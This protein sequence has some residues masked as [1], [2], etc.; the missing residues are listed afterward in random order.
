MI[1]TWRWFGPNDPITL[2][3]VRQTGAT[4]IVTS[5]HE[6][7]VGT[8]WTAQDVAERKQM[9]E[10]AGLTWQVC[11]SIPVADAIK[12]GA[13]EAEAL[14][15]A[16][17][18][19]LRA[20]GRAGVPV[21]CYN[22]MPVVDWTRTT[23]THPR[24]D[25]ARAL[26]FEFADF[27]AYDLFMLGRDAASDYPNALVDRARDR[28]TAMDDAAR[29]TLEETV[30][31]GL[32]GGADG[33]TRDALAR[34]IAAFDGLTADDVRANLRRFLQAVVPV[35]Q[36]VG[37]DL[38]IHPDDPPLALFGLP[39]VVSSAA[40]VEAILD[41]SDSPANGITLCCGSYGA[42]LANNVEAMAERFAHR[43]NFAHLRNVTVDQDGS[44]EEAPHLGGRV[45]MVRVITALRAEERNSART[46]PMRPDHGHLFNRD[47]GLPSNPGYS[48][49]GRLR[50]LAELRGIS[51]AIDHAHNAET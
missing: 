14:T 44:F 42:A 6:I 41:V 19:S 47:A 43:V 29:Q 17:I 7:P 30:I 25:G 45:D 28:F 40:D 21:V 11:E 35:A 24:P 36:E 27:V 32:P 18:A 38:A 13:P 49:I 3:D 23:L 8:A 1:E 22:F 50:G 9:I 31:A 10:A 26:R 46:I 16:W 51:A 39:R 33:L 15:D 34:E 37:V 20:L 4:G 48:Y 5:L 2:A 12:R